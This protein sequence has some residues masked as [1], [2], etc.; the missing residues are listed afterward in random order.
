MICFSNEASSDDYELISS[1]SNVSNQYIV[2]HKQSR[3]F[4]LVVT[5][6]A[7][8]NLE[9][10][11]TLFFSP[12]L[13]GNISLTGLFCNVS[14]LPCDMLHPCQNSG[15]CTNTNTSATTTTTYKC[16]C[17]QGFAGTNCELDL[18]PCKSNTCLHN[19]KNLLLRLLGLSKRLHTSF[20]YCRHVH[21]SSTWKLLVLVCIWMGRNELRDHDQCVS[22]YHLSEPRCVCRPLRLSSYECLCLSDYSGDRCEVRSTRTATLQIVARSFVSIAVAALVIV[23][24]FIV[25]LDVLKYMF[26]I[27]PVQ[28]ERDELQ[29]TKTR[30]KRRRLPFHLVQR[31]IYVP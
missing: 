26:H 14:S 16:L 20:D 10:V 13:C 12:R 25:T 21:Y 15:T 4:Y 24:G 6:F 23:A 27:D 29:E 8:E 3:F 18:R 1:I 30:V 31:F 7:I 5:Y 2:F 9:P 19:G 11:R 22:Q 28:K 17:V